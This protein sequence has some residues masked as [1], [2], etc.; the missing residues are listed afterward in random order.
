[1]LL[2]LRGDGRGGHSSGPEGIRVEKPFLRFAL[3]AP[4][5]MTVLAEIKNDSMR[6]LRFPKEAE[7]TGGTIGAKTAGEVDRSAGTG[8]DGGQGSEPGEGE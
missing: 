5:E 2:Q 4:V 8:G 6:C 3:C 7:L 1:M